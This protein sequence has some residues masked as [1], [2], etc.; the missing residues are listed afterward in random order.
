MGH[1]RTAATRT[2]TSIAT[3]RRQGP[4]IELTTYR[5]RFAADEAGQGI[6][7]NPWFRP[8]RIAALRYFRTDWNCSAN[9]F[10]F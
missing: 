9:Q 10:V 7:L 2:P 1:E 8:Q 3:T 5:H 4:P 6:P